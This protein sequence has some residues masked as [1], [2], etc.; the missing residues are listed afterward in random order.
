MHYLIRLY[1][2]PIGNPKCNYATWSSYDSSC[3]TAQNPCGRGE[4]DC[5]EDYQCLGDL[6]CGIDNCG[7]QFPVGGADCCTGNLSLLIS[8]TL[9]PFLY[10]QKLKIENILLLLCYHCAET[11]FDGFKNQGEDQID[12]GGPCFPC[13]K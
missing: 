9:P 3:C 1:V 7:S 6:V 11:C 12:C 10:I 13:R 5:D 2:F 4:G 8:I